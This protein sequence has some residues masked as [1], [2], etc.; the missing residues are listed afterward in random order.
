MLYGVICTTHKR[1]VLA[2]EFRKGKPIPPLRGEFSIERGV[3]RRERVA[4]VTER[5]SLGYGCGA[6]KSLSIDNDIRF[7][8]AVRHNFSQPASSYIDG[9]VLIVMI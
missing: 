5:Q 8:N 2:G 4:A 7:L 1:F 9:T 6:H 3:G